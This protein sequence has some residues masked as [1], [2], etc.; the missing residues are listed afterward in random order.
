MFSQSLKLSVHFFNEEPTAAARQLESLDPSAS[1]LLLVKVPLSS[2][3]HVLKVMLPSSAAKIVENLPEEY[4]AS[5]FHSLELA[6]IAAI[7]RYIKAPRRSVLLALLPLKKQTICRLLIS[8]PEHTIGSMIESNVLVLNSQMTV[9]DALIRVK[10]HDYFDTHE[11]VVVDS[12]RKLFGK[13]SLHELLR[14]PAATIIKT[15]CKRTVDS[16]S[17]FSDA[18]A[19]L[20]SEI[21]K[22]SDMVTVIN[23]KQEFIGILRH[24]DLRAALSHIKVVD[25]VSNAIPGE[26]LDAYG[27][28]LLTV[29]DVFI[30]AKTPNPAAQ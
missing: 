19:V 1:A 29:L 7:L 21:W 6:E 15:I 26:I 16:L 22:K 4:T 12:S 11:I 18:R 23:R 13:T 20:A 17:G 3:T 24:C 8:Y 10:K 25:E 5:V 9:A 28:V 27:T 30:P 2:A 14:K